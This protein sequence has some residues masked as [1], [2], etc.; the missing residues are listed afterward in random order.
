M[1]T[2]IIGLILILNITAGYSLNFVTTAESISWNGAYTSVS[3][4]FESMLYNPAGLYMTNSRFG[5]NIL[6]SA[7]LR[8]FSNS[9]TTDNILN[10]LKSMEAGVNLSSTGILSKMLLY[11]PDTGAQFGIDASALNFMTYSKINDFSI[12]V[13]LIPKTSLS[14]ILDKGIFNAVFNQLDLTKTQS[15]DSKFV[16]LQYLDLN[17]MLSTRAKFLEK[18][19]PGVEKIYVGMGFHWYLPTIFVKS[20]SKIDIKSGAPDP[21]SGAISDYN[22]R[23]HGTTYAGANGLFIGILS[24]IPQ[25][26]NN[27]SGLLKY[28]GSAA[29]GMGF[30]FGVMLQFNRFVRLGF[31][32][33]DI[34]FIVFP[35]AAL[36]KLDFNLGLNSDTFKN[37]QNTLTKDLRKEISDIKNYKP[38]QAQW[39]MPDTA[40]RLGVAVTPFRN[41]LFIWASDVSLSGFNN[42]L[43]G[44]YPVFNISTGIEYKP[45]YKWFA[46]PMRTALSYNTQS[47]NISLSFGLG[48]YLGPVEMEI[49]IKGIEFLFS[50]IGAKELCAGYDLKFEF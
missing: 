46:V 29:F 12:G 3:D 35:Q 8:L 9:I 33:T 6:G 34:G 44:G 11:M 22:I 23:V 1:K 15:F 16:M 30:D 2:T 19:L 42:M 43:Y 39:W 13:Y 36:L 25:N 41:D 38:S 17:T 49:G 37:F 27:I 21:V 50:G 26:Y 24:G 10:L 32:F 40:L 28:G 31:S 4:G 20:E 45:G 48:L 47:N 18:A 14:I 7:G 5:I